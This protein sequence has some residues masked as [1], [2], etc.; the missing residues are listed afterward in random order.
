[1]EIDTDSMS[2]ANPQRAWRPS[3]APGGR[4][5]SGVEAN[6]SA[7]R[8]RES[9]RATRGRT[10]GRTVTKTRAELSLV[11]YYSFRAP[12]D[13]SASLPRDPIID[14]R[15][16]KD[17][18]ELLKS[19]PDVSRTHNPRGLRQRFALSE[20]FSSARHPPHSRFR[21]GRR[22]VGSS[23]V[24]TSHMCTTL[25]EEPQKS[26]LRPRT[27]CTSMS[28]SRGCAG[29]SAQAWQHRRSW[30]KGCIRYGQNTADE[31]IPGGL[32]TASTSDW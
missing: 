11:L 6:G 18:L 10:R 28:F 29:M 1:M 31:T 25:S 8:K 19:K 9:R 17:H 24:G 2:A 21:H 16:M 15:W 3:P 14:S 32:R 30:S 12:P 27:S 22:V 7:R 23:V 4:W 20:R 13:I 26:S 5:Q